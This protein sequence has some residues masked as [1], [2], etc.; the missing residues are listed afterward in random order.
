MALNITTE[1]TT[2]PL[3]TQEVKDHVRVDISDDDD[4]IDALITAAR[5]SAETF[6]NRQF[7]TATY[8]L[9]LDRFP[10][11]KNGTVIKLS[12]PP[13]VSVTTVKYF[14]IDGAQQTLVADTD[15]QVDVLSEPG[16]L[17]PAPSTFWPSVQAQRL[18]PIEIIYIA[19]YGAAGAVPQGIKQALLLLVG[20]WYERRETV[21]VGSISKE[22]EFTTKS[23]LINDKIPEVT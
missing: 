20:H 5:K 1:P 12:R 13:I 22:L 21:L 23:L 10:R 11:G 2:E 9:N 15:Y 6:T 19:G 4:Y 3:T 7:I 16:R 14:D 17:A 8:T 18:N